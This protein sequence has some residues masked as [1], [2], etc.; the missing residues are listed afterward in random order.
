[1]DLDG[2]IAGNGGVHMAT[3][4]IS[5]KMLRR[6]ALYLE[7]LRAL[8]DEVENISASIM[9]RPAAELHSAAIC[10]RRRSKP[11]FCS[12]DCGYII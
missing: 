1:M 4:K 12:N 10:S 3:N 6:L 7:Y 11:I 5:K 9:A 8:P 2:V